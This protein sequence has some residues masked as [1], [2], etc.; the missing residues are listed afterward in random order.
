[1]PDLRKKPVLAESLQGLRKRCQD[2][3]FYDFDAEYLPHQAEKL[4]DILDDLLTLL[5]D[6]VLQSANAGKPQATK[7]AQK[8]A[9]TKKN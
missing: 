9:N 5:Q 1:M 4:K 6:D 3:S 2:L 7:K 8:S